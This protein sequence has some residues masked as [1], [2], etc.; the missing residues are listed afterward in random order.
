MSEYSNYANN[1]EERTDSEKKRNK[2]KDKYSEMGYK[3]D[4]I[5][6]SARHPHAHR[7]ERV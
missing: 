4:N 5:Y 1:T 7:Y 3:L 2:N 6:K